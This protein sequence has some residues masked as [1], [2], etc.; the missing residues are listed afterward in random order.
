MITK[1]T[2]NKTIF[3]RL[4]FV[5]SFLFLSACVLSQG[6]TTAPATDDTPNEMEVKSQECMVA[7]K[8]KNCAQCHTLSEEEAL[9]VLSIQGPKTIKILKINPSQIPGLWEVYFNFKGRRTIAYIDYSKKYFVSGAIIDYAKKENLTNIRMQELSRVDVSRIP[10]EN[11]LL[12]GSTSARYK[13]FVFDDPDCGYCK[14]LHDEMKKVIEKNPDIAF[15][16][17]LFPLPMHRQ[18]YAKSVTIACEKSLQLME[19]NFAGKEIPSKKCA[20]TEVDDN[21]KLA[22]E[23]GITGTPTLVMSNG[24]VIPGYMEADALIQKVLDNA[25]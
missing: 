13:V 11:A 3:L 15:Y 5:F 18:A 25:Q 2:K 24:I 4:I 1:Y 7:G 14:K 20:L 9:D 8:E 17:K 6:K 23:F 10:T 22:E 21:I 12:I 16:I 19:D